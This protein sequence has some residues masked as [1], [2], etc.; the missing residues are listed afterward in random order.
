[1][2]KTFVV[3][4]FSSDKQFFLSWPEQKH[5]EAENKIKHTWNGDKFELH[6]EANV[7]RV[8]Q[9]WAINGS[10]NDYKCKYF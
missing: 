5:I 4:L 3:V 6:A 10:H 7:E 2:I 1:M 8:N 9:Q